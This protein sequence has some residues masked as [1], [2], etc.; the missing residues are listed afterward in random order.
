MVE[1]EMHS[2]S[3]RLVQLLEARTTF[4]MAALLIAVRKKDWIAW[5]MKLND[6]SAGVRC[7]LYY[8]I[9]RES[10]VSILRAVR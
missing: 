7:Y 3:S 4:R 9:W 2:V 6:G 1:E 10:L 5:R 8:P